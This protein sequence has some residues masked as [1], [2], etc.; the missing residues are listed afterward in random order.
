[1]REAQQRSRVKRFFA[2]LWE[3]LKG[4]SIPIT[5]CAAFFASLT[6]LGVYEGERSRQQFEKMRHSYEMHYEFVKFV[7]AQKSLLPCYEAL[8]ELAEDDLKSV[9]M[10]DRTRNFALSPSRHASLAECLV[11]SSAAVENPEQW[12]PATTRLIRSA[13]LRRIAAIDAPLLSYR[14]KVGDPGVIC[15][16]FNGYIQGSV[17]SKFL[18]RIIAAGILHKGNYPNLVDFVTKHGD[19]QA[20]PEIKLTPPRGNRIL[21]WYENL[22]TTLA[23]EDTAPRR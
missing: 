20:C 4:L 17:I 3:A 9:L 10:Y 15:E 5:A 8:N 23:G 22:L 11:D 13:V 2:G 14:Q 21:D 12:G 16:N 18:K 6:A 7:T 1:M 19:G